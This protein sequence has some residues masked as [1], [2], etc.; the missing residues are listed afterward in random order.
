MMMC[1]VETGRPSFD[2][3]NTTDAVLNSMT[4]PRLGVTSVILLP[5]VYIT[6]YP[7]VASPRTMPSPPSARSTVVGS[8]KFRRKSLPADVRTAAMGPMAFA[9]SF[10]PCANAT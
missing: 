5:I 3:S 8:P 9:A 7:Y 4:K 10:D 6:L 1:V 2:P